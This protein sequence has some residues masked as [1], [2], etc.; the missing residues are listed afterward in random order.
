MNVTS[1]VLSSKPITD[2]DYS[3]NIYTR[4]KGKIRAIAKGIFKKNSS[5]RSKIQPFT[6][7]YF[8]IIETK[9]FNLITEGEI[10]EFNSSLITELNKIYCASY[11]SKVFIKF[12][13]EK[14]KDEELYEILKDF[15]DTVSKSDRCGKERTEKLDFK[16]ENNLDLRQ[17][18]VAFDI[19]FMK[20]QGVLPQNESFYFANKEI[21]ERYEKLR[22]SDLPQLELHQLIELENYISSLYLRNYSHSRQFNLD[23]FL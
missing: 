2:N 17:I 22:F 5:L 10:L 18:V 8:K 11:G 4:E 1:I 16:A 6:E 21:F 19:K 20:N 23:T 15:F 9:S 12:L 14:S 13:P 7:S 3:V